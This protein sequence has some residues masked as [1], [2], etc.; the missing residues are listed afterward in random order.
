MKSKIIC[1]YSTVI[2]NKGNL[3]YSLKKLF[4]QL[5]LYNECRKVQNFKRSEQFFV[6]ELLVLIKPFYI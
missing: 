2:N 1:E 6:E 5:Y 3:L 4:F